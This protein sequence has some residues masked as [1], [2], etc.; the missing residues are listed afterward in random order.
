MQGVT[1]EHLHLPWGA[2]EFGVIAVEG[3]RKQ[4]TGGVANPGQGDAVKGR[5]YDKNP[6]QW[7]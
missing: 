4:Q 6:M 7:S 5:R 2:T 3:G 1:A